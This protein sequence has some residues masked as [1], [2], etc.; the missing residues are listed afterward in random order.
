MMP[1]IDAACDER[2]ARTSDRW[3]A[4]CPLSAILPNTGVCAL[5]GRRQIAVV[6][7]GAGAEVYALSNFDP[8]SKA[9]VLSRGIVG[10]RGGTPKIASPV[11][12]QSFDLRTGQ[13]LDDPAVRVPTFP[14]RVR[15]GAVEVL[16]V[17]DDDPPAGGEG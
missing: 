14:V 9:F 8:F 6:R 13:C 11:Y 17:A 7:V 3:V 10:D 2:P 5:L 15:G 4:V 1:A 16:A 12:K